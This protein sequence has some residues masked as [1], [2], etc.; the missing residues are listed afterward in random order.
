MNEIFSESKSEY[1][2]ILQVREFLKTNEN[3]YKIGKT[4]Q[5]FNKR[6]NNYP[7]G[8]VL[9][10]QMICNNC[11]ILEKDI[12]KMFKEK[13]IQQK[14]LG[15]EYFKGDYNIMIDDIYTIIKNERELCNE[16]SNKQQMYNENIYEE[17]EK[18]HCKI[19]DKK[20]YVK[21]IYNDKNILLENLIFTESQLKI[22]YKHLFFGDEKNKKTINNW[23]YNNPTIM[24][25][26]TIEIYPN[27]IDV[28][29]KVYNLWVP[30]KIEQMD[31]EYNEDLEK[32][33]F[34]LNYIKILCN[35]DEKNYQYI[36]N[37]LINMLK[38]P[39]DKPKTIPIFYFNYDIHKNNLILLLE[40]ILGENK[41]IKT[42]DIKN[43]WKNNKIKD[44]FL[45]CFDKLNEINNKIEDLINKDTFD[46]NLK[47]IK[48]KSYHRYIGFLNKNELYIPYKNTIFININTNDELINNDE[49]YKK[50]KEYIHDENAIKS[51]YYFLK[52][53]EYEEINNNEVKFDLFLWF[54]ENYELTNNKKKFLKIKDI[55]NNFYN[56]IS[57][58]N[59]L[60][61]EKKMYNKKYFNEYFKQN[62]EFSKYYSERYDSQR[63]VIR[64]WVEKK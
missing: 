56:N 3:I 22:Y 44:A 26:N 37:W 13:Y 29:D 41:I 11:D 50:F 59:L 34:F 8:S 19:I 55:Y 51:F 31:K 42:S 9:L 38:F 57:T 60:N 32:L 63:N 18:T 30:F 16:N 43:I 53:K 48:L 24:S 17:F 23:I 39:E 15:N 7:N 21:K 25:Y 10:F 40:L 28:N 20:I 12:I 46:I 4:N 62:L 27:N 61:Y 54:K 36:L 49:Y 35:N 2:Y 45:I 5:K 58:L 47:N 33:N 6:F 52:N 64:F 1:I 14:D